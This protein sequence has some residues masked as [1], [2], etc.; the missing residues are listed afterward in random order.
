MS[1]IPKSELTPKKREK[2]LRQGGPEGDR[3]EFILPGK[4]PGDYWRLTT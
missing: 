1:W 3:L 4:N 2:V